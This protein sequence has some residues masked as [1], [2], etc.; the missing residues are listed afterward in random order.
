MATSAQHR[1]R[2]ALFDLDG[3]LVDTNYL[4]V[5]TWWQALHQ[6]GHEV[7][8]ARVHRAIGMGGDRILEH[9][10]GEEHDHRDDQALRDAHHALYAAWFDSLPVLD[11]AP[12]LLREIAARGLRVILASSASADEV[13]AIRAALD[14]D[15][16][17]AGATSADDV[18]SS[19]PAPDLVCQALSLA[20]VEPADAVFVGD[21][22]WDVKAAARAGV[23]CIALLTGGISEAELT[24]AGPAT[25]YPGP[26]ELL[27][28]L[29][30]SPLAGS[31]RD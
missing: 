20:D 1:P 8:M 25:V 10:L 7:P 27:H 5:L 24:A 30:S 13:K 3:T 16:V 6:H 26:P 23:T 29:D 15:E 2:A 19:K 31:P 28:G 21:T 18:D 11:R 22:V 14:V 17:I 4:H 9:L 12:D